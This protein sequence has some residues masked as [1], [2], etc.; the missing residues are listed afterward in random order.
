[1]TRGIVI[2]K[3]YPPHKGH[4]AMIDFAQTKVDQLTVIVCDRKDQ[5]ISGKLRAKWLKQLH[6][7]TKVIIVKD[8]CDD[9]N[10]KRWANYTLKFLG[11]KPDYVITSENYGDP[12][13]KYMG[14]QHILYDKARKITPI[15]ARYIRKN[16]LK[17]WD[18]YSEQV[19]TYYTKRICIL[20]AES[21]GSTTMA[22][23]L[24]KH[25]QTCW[26][27]EYGRIYS[28]GKLKNKDNKWQTQEFIHIAKMQNYMEDKLAEK[29]NKILICD[30]NSFTTAVWHQR[31]MDY[32]SKQVEKISQNR[33]IDLYLLTDIDIPFV[34]DGTRD[35]Q[36]IRKEMHQQFIKALKK[37]NKPYILLSGNH[38]NR[39]KTAVNAINNI[40]KN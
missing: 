37:R 31:Y 24:A 20:G 10:S 22:K 15:C 28:E 12:Y 30:T 3:F 17:Y 11:Y 21:T 26:V 25:Y 39:L 13:A 2:G 19:K 4:S 8:I 14:C 18:Y 32:W 23:A 36:H 35:G 16:P 9:D 6:P 40:L 27:P 33:K 5:T 29:C 7:Q 38:K 1:M 34:Q